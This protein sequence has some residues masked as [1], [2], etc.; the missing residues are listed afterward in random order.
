MVA[1]GV[2]SRKASGLS[3]AISV[4][5]ALLQHRVAGLLHHQVAG[6]A[7]RGLDDDGSHA[8]RQQPLQ[9]RRKPG[10]VSIMSAPGTASS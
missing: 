7:V 3:A 5:A 4:D 1:V 6:E 10:R 9:H 8:V 2:S